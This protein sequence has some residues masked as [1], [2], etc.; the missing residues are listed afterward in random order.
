MDRNTYD[1]FWE[2]RESLIYLYKIGDINK[3]EFIELNYRYIDSMNVAP[4]HRIDNL[5]KGVF[6]YQYYNM[7]A[8]YFQKE[9]NRSKK[10][11]MRHRSMME[12]A[13]R[14]YHKKD[15]S[16]LRTLE[17]M[18]F[19]GIEAYPVKVRSSY[20]KG[21]LIEIILDDYENIVLHTTSEL[22]RQK[23][24]DEMVYKD[25]KRKSVVDSYI[26]QRY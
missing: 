21:K 15:I 9:G 18:K 2:N 22:I 1:A 20:L 24:I 6:N 26:N 17:A 16:T 7:L 8:K 3:N 12:K 25:E 10:G 11:S 5:E 19:T 13:G 23:L 14:F 4:Y